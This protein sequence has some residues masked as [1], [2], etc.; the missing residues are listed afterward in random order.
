MSIID[1]P[2]RMPRP[3]FLASWELARLVEPPVVVGPD[4]TYRTTEATAALRRGSTD[5]LTRLGL[6]STDGALTPQYRATLTVLAA[7]ERELYSWSNFPQPGNDGAIQ[8]AASGRDAVRLITDH[9]IIQLDPILPRNLAVSLVE[10]LPDYRP[11][12][13]SQLRVPQAYLDGT[14]ADPLSEMSGPADEMRHL[15]RAERVGVHKLYA[16]VRN[17]GDRIRSTPLTVYDLSRSGRILAFTS[18]ADN[19]GPDANMG[20]GNRT[21]LIDALNLTLNGLQ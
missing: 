12:R 13:I 4:Q 11:A 9:Q 10:T 6:A 19:G 7:A 1:K 3:V 16:A 15:M 18:E 14:N 8:V 20:P 17:N 5:I 2:V 21:N